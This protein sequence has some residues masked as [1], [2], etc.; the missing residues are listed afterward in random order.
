M[1]GGKCR[2]CPEFWIDTESFLSY[3]YNSPFISLSPCPIFLSGKGVKLRGGM[4]DISVKLLHNK[5]RH[6]FK[7]FF[8]L[9]FHSASRTPCSHHSPFPSYF[10][11]QVPETATVGYLKDL[12]QLKLG[13]PS[14]SLRV[15]VNGRCWPGDWNEGDI[16]GLFCPLALP[17]LSFFFLHSFPQEHFYLYLFLFFERYYVTSS[18]RTLLHI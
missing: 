3:I 13:I 9:L 8:L 4:R 18:V 11:I 7:V 1:E 5:G 6:I 17:L 16:S 15:V 2:N 14:S 10:L 12:I